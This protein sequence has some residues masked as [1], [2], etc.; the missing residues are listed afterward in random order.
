MSTTVSARTCEN[1]STPRLVPAFISGMPVQIE[2]PPWCT[3]DHATDF[4]LSP[5]DVWHGSDYSDLK[6][7]VIGRPED[8]DVVLFA[9]L[10]LDPASQNPI[11][12]SPFIVV[13]D[14]ADAA[15]MTPDGAEVFADNLEAF[16]TQIRQMA[17]S[18]RTYGGAR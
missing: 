16:A 14:S 2:C 7:P 18:A 15:D 10:G 11:R 9:R 3:N 13:A 12:R 6:A 5:E 8:Q 4:A 17:R 1:S